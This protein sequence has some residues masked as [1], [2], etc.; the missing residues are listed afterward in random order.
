MNKLAL[1]L[2]IGLL[3]IPSVALAKGV[4]LIEVLDLLE[5]VEPKNP[6]QK[7]A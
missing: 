2:L 7:S 3:M 1:P 5:A 4:E 6:E